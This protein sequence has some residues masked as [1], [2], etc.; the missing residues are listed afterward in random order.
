MLQ[1][2]EEFASMLPDHRTLKSSWPNYRDGVLLKARACKD[3]EL[4]HT[5]VDD[6]D[7][8]KP[9]KC[10]L[11]YLLIHPTCSTGVLVLALIVVVVVLSGF[12]FLHRWTVILLLNY[13]FCKN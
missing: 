13:S 4:V 2:E 12:L 9:Y 10:I 3:A 5:D 8:G 6:F 7:E 11:R 1:V